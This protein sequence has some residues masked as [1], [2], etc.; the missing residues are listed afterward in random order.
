M[1]GYTGKHQGRL[2]GKGSILFAFEMSPKSTHVFGA[3]SPAGGTILGGSGDWNVEPS[4]R[5]WITGGVT[6]GAVSCSRFL[7]P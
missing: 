4:W 5:K 6:L 7:P 2:G 1:Q 3:W